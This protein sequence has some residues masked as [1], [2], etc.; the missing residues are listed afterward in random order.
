MATLS[1]I[2]WFCLL[3]GIAGLFFVFWHYQGIEN[4]LSAILRMMAAAF[5]G[6]IFWLGLFIILMALLFLNASR[7][8]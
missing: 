8:E 4:P 2:G 1:K 3:I 5:W 7:V 6:G